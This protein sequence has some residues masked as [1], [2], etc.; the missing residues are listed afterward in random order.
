MANDNVEQLGSSKKG[1]VFVVDPNPPGMDIIPP[2]DMFIYVKFSAFPRSRT[3]YGGNTLEGSP[4]VFDSGIDG[5]VHFISTKISYKDGKLDPPLQQTY[6]T[7]DWTNIGGFKDED[8]RSAG[9]LEGF[10]IKSIDIKYNASLVPVVDITFTDVR[11]SGLFDVVKNNDRKSPYSIFFKMPYPVFRLSV[12]GY[13]GQKVDYCLHM[14]N[15]TSNFDGSTGNFDISANFLGFQQAFLNDMVIGNI[16]GVVN[17][18]EG[19]NNLNDIYDTRQ[20]NVGLEG[21]L[22]IRKL[23]EFFTKI[24]RLQ[25]DSE[26]IKTDLDSFELLK[27][28][29]GKMSLLKTIR[30]FIGTS[31]P[32]EVKSNS[33]GTPNDENEDTPYIQKENSINTIFTSPIRDNNLQNNINYLSI[34]DYVVFNTVDRASFKRYIETL[35]DIIIKYDEYL[36]SNELKPVTPQNTVGSTEKKIKIKGAKDQRLLDSFPRNPDASKSWEEYIVSPTKTPDNVISGTTLE[37]IIGEFSNSGSTIYLKNDYEG[38][39]QNNKNFNLELFKSTSFY[40]DLKKDTTVLVADF[41]RQRELVEYN[42][43]ELEEEIKK[44][45]EIVQ[46]ELN[47]KLLGNFKKQFGFNPTINKCFE[48]LANNTQAMIQTVYDIS[49]KAEEQNISTTRSQ[50]LSTYETD[51]PTDVNSLA[52]PTVYQKNNDGGLEE[53]YIGELNTIDSVNFPEWYFT[54]RVFENLVAKTKTLEQVTKASTLK[55]GLDTDNWFPINPIDYEINPWIRLGSLTDEPAITNELVKQFFYRS[56]I[57]QNYSLFDKTTGLGDISEY[58]NLEAIAANKTIFSEQ[59]RNIIGN[60]LNKMKNNQLDFKNTD[61]FRENIDDEVTTYYFKETENVLPTYNNFTLSGKFSPKADYI[62]FD[63]TKIINNSKRLFGEILSEKSYGDLTNPTNPVINKEENKGKLFYKN[64]YTDANNFNTNNIFNVWDT[65]VSKNLIKS[66]NNKITDTFINSK[67]GDFNPSGNTNGSK[68]LNITNFNL[69]EETEE[70]AYEDILTQSEL[71]RN[72]TSNYSR[73]LL[74]LSTFPFRTFKEGFLDSVFPNNTFRGARIVKLPKLYVYYLGG[75]LWRYEEGLKGNNVVDFSV[76]F[77]GGCDYSKFQSTY[78]KYLSI[79]YLKGKDIE[80]EDSLKSLPQSVKKT[81]IFKFQNWVNGELRF[82]DNLNGNFETNMTYYVNDGD[83]ITITPTDTEKG[84][85][86]IFK[87]LKETTDMIILNPSIFN[88]SIVNLSERL[89][90]KFADISQYIEK[91]ATKFQSVGKDNNNGNESNTEKETSDETNRVNQIKL[92]IYNYFKNINSKWVGQDEKSFNIC[93]GDDNNDLID[94]FRFIDRGWRDI[95]D[96]A[97]FNLKS[98]LTL[99]SN[100][101]TSVYFFMSKL[102]RDSNFLFQIL[103]NYINYKDAT[104]VAKIFQPQTILEKNK[105]SGPIFC[106]IYVGGASEVLDIEET[107]SNRNNYYFKN[108]GFSFNTGDLPAD[109]TSPG[110]KVTS[111]SNADEDLE[112]S[113]LV[114]FRVSFGAQNQTVFK[115]VSLSQQEHR[116]TGEYFKAL[117]DLVDK[118]GGTQKTYVGTDL[119]RLFKTRSYT[120][121]VDALGCMN[122]QPLMYFDLQNVPFFNGA[123]M[124]TSVNHN[125]TPNHM[126]TNFQG[127]R[128]SKY[129]SPPTDEITADLNINLNESSEVPKIVFTNLDVKSG[130]FNIGVRTGIETDDLFDFDANFTDDNFA[131]LGVDSSFPIN[132]LRTVLEGSDIKTNSQVTMLLTAMLANSNNFK[133]KEKSFN[134]GDIIT[135]TDDNKIYYYTS[136]ADGDVTTLNDDSLVSEY[137]DTYLAS[138]STTKITGSSANIAYGTDNSSFDESKKYT[139]ILNSIESLQNR[140]N[141]LDETDPNYENV[142]KKYEK[143]IEN[144]EKSKENLINTTNYFNIFPGDAYR[145]KPRGYLYVIGRKNYYD[146]FEEVSEGVISSESAIIT[147]T[148][149]TKNVNSTLITSVVAWK[150]LKDSTD[151]SAFDYSSINDDGSAS[152]FKRCFDIVYQG[153]S[154]ADDTTTFNVFEKVLTTFRGKDGQPLIDYDKPTGPV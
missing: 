7:T 145:F 134:Q 26:I 101:N 95:G 124:I 45:T 137:K 11:G 77:G 117:S 99:G 79:G 38:S 44:Q 75:L 19:L 81:L 84:K 142:K 24:A 4:L 111:N 37:T 83:S 94:Y 107:G 41:R 128:Q 13:F 122:I 23:D 1:S 36:T 67:I 125:I 109:M 104:E 15:W 54:E 5:E 91:F 98:F 51:I 90:I 110:E 47:E 127:V 66:S 76:S 56:A 133:D 108:D 93:G 150:G 18:E 49:K 6:A 27:D 144:L 97:T 42:I 114:A 21:D 58:A 126:T 30:S 32:K 89:E 8:S 96:K 12:K 131:I 135:S 116:E 2:E 57:L 34:R 22:N 64:K 73:A 88:T 106:C 74:L 146:L 86:Y 112:D 65:G 102:L 10:G 132:E 154:S 55:N 63:N 25:V 16:I 100:L 82:S 136:I 50:L 118:R 87:Q 140:I 103:P 28:L 61:F 14:V 153:Q 71:Y 46:T 29:N 130:R 72:Q 139:D 59:T 119:L 113:S 39:N 143:E 40:K 33:S 148:T 43:Q 123:Y 129:I 120:C 20:S 68:Y 121:K 62:L 138:I 3:T 53:V 35:N 69:G 31:L 147:P 115:N 92:Q 85:A 52:W 60:I 48:I 149:L 151:K 141:E 78:D 17:T 105:S 70:C 152:T 9:I 80:L